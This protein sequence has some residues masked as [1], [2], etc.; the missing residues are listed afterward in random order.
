MK[1]DMGMFM[2]KSGSYGIM[3]LVL[4]VFLAQSPSFADE[5]AEEQPEAVSEQANSPV[6]SADTG[7]AAKRL[8][9]LTGEVDP[10]FSVEVKPED[11]NRVQKDLAGLAS[12]ASLPPVEINVNHCCPVRLGKTE[13]QL[14]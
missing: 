3:F 10:K 2:K 1:G 11:L 13:T 12:L 5:P 8:V 7:A 4:G 14:G 6:A 9:T